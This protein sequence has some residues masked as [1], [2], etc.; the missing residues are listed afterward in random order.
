M[1]RADCCVR[2]FFLFALPSLT[3]CSC[4]SLFVCVQHIIRLIREHD[5]RCECIYLHVKD[6]NSAAIAMYRRCGFRTD[7]FLYDHY[8]IEGQ[9]YN[10]IKMVK[11]I[12]TNTSIYDDIEEEA[13]GWCS[14]M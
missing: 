11:W 10:A 3:L 5:R 7:E 4:V 9:D 14:V 13:R 6:S 8:H 1:H 12:N 2:W